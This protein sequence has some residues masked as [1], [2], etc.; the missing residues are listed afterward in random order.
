MRKHV[1]IIGGGLSALSC[2]Y[3]LI[4]SGY[5]VSIIEKSDRLGGLASGFKQESWEYSLEKFYH[6]I[7]TTDKELCSLLKEINYKGMN[8]YQVSTQSL[9]Q[10]DD[11]YLAY[12]LDSPKALLLFPLLGWVDKARAALILIFCKFSPFLPFFSQLKA[13]DFLIRTMGIKSYEILWK[14]LFRKKFGKYAENIL[15]SFFWARVKTRSQQLGYPNGGFNTIVQALEE[16]LKKN[17][18]NIYKENYVTSIKRVEEQYQVCIKSKKLIA[19]YIVC[20]TPTS[21]F[22]RILNELLPQPSSKR[23]ENLPTLAAINLILVTTKP[24]LTHAYWMNICVADVLP[25]VLVQHTNLIGKEHYGGEHIAYIGNYLEV[26]SELFKKSDTEVYEEYL[27]H[28][29]RIIP[30]FEPSWIKKYFVY[31]AEVA[32]PL[33]TKDFINAGL[34]HATELKNVYLANL[35]TT[36]PYDRGTNFAVKNGKTVAALIKESS[37]ASINI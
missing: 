13:V 22:N 18:A 8:F 32:Q 36:Y 34:T 19:D 3:Y 17:K 12:N 24:L 28:I 35:D 16:Y 20:T 2:A 30:E 1:V 26:D 11:K 27:P 37:F 25:M 6:H 14:Q 29:K 23:V 9:Y 31:R 5:L 7:F 21:I 4:K 33:Y 15:M 10:V